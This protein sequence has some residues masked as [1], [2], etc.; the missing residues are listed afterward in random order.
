MLQT[1][2]NVGAIV[3]ATVALWYG[4][5]AFVTGASRVARRLGVPQIVI[6]LTVVAFGTS[7]PE[8][9]VT[10]EAALG[11][12]ADVSIGNVVGSNLLNLGAVLGGAALVAALPTDRSFLR[13]DGAV[14]VATTLL[15]FGVLWDL[16]VSQLDGLVL[17]GLL[18]AYL[19]VLAR[20]RNSRVAVSTGEF[21]LPDVLRLVAGLVLVIVGGRLLVIG[22]TSLARAAGLSEWVIGVTIVAAGTSTPELVTSVAAA[23]AGRGSIAAGNVVGSCIFNILGVLGVAALLGPLTVAPAAIGS[24]AWLTTLAVLVTLLFYTGRQL[25]RPEGGVLV[26]VFGLNW[27]LDFL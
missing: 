18:I 9:A 15:A 4:A 10:I 11:G 22:G 16:Q 5:E 1:A 3:V 13:R 26:A 23:R 2:L 14:L 12:R 19:V 24:M 21:H 17:I 20:Q 7:A 6:G 25:S 27:L 8:F